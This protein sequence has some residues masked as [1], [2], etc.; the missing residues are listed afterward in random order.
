MCPPFGFKLGPQT[1]P[2]HDPK[3]VPK[4][5]QKSLQKSIPEM[6]PKLSQNGPQKTP[7]SS[8]CKLLFFDLVS[9]LAPRAPGDPLLMRSASKRTLRKRKL[10]VFMCFRARTL[11]AHAKTMRFYKF[12]SIGAGSPSTDRHQKGQSRVRTEPNKDKAEYGQSP[13]GTKPSTDRAQK[14]QS[15]VRTEPERDKAEYGQSPTRTTPSA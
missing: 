5:C 15:R 1:G 6:M 14:R 4:R 8:R 9:D 10:H 11:R 13:T 7:F 2:T 12:S 3:T